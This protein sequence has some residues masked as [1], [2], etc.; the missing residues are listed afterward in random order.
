MKASCG[1]LLNEQGLDSLERMQNAAGRMQT[2]IDDLLMLSRVT[3]KAQPFV[4]VDPNR[5]V[6]K[7]YPI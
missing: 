5:V 6:K 7:Y 3:T 4:T 1:D 2:L